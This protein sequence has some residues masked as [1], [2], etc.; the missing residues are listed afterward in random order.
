MTAS[1][2]VHAFGSHL[3][4]ILLMS[5]VDFPQTEPIVGLWMAGQRMTMVEACWTD[6]QDKTSEKRP[7]ELSRDGSPTIKSNDWSM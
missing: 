7:T 2:V 3:N 5:M 6:L 1:T 4:H